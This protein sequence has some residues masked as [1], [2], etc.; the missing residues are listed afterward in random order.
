MM[1]EEGI[2][3]GHD[4]FVAV[5]ESGIGLHVDEQNGQSLGGVPPSR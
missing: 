2:R 1:E 5:R 4:H 3:G